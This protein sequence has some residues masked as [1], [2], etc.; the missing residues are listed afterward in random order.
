MNHDT[1]FLR[2]TPCTQLLKLKSIATVLVDTLTEEMEDEFKELLHNIELQSTFS[3]TL[4]NFHTT[5]QSGL[6]QRLVRGGKL[7]ISQDSAKESMI[8]VYHSGLGRAWSTKGAVFMCTSV[9]VLT[10]T[11]RCPS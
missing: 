7:A 3:D 2:Q 8:R 1:S 11:L 5:L 9:Q 6:W 4:N 10:M